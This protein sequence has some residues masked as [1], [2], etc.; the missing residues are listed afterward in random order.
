MKEQKDIFN[1]FNKKD[2]DNPDA[3]YFEH[4]ANN[5]IEKETKKKTVTPLFKKPSFWIIAAAASLA[6]ILVINLPTSQE[7]NFLVALNDFSSNEIVGYISQNITDFDS[8]L[9]TEYISE[10]DI[11]EP[12]L[13]TIEDLEIIEEAESNI[14]LENIDSQ[15]ILDYF[16]SEEIDIYEEDFELDYDEL[17]I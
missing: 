12:V 11:E 16:D 15:E 17:Y 2:S 13:A 4:M 5:I 8:E 9:I 1:Y 14:R 7:D 6:F 10:N 3:S